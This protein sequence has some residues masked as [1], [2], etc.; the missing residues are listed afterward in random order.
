MLHFAVFCI[1]KG[2]FFRV[3]SLQ[4]QSTGQLC[5]IRN[6]I[7]SASSYNGALNAIKVTHKVVLL[8]YVPWLQIIFPEMTRIQ[9]LLALHT[10][11][12]LC[13]INKLY[14]QKIQFKGGLVPQGIIRNNGVTVY[15]QDTRILK[16]VKQQSLFYLVQYDAHS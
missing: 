2:P 1:L 5:L 4:W 8:C 16:F 12:V 11:T 15:G 6:R 14:S 10:S 3:T 13:R 9:V 7:V